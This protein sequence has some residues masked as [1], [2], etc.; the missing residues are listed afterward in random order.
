MPVS[1]VLPHDEKT[2]TALTRGGPFRLRSPLIRAALGP[3]DAIVVGGGS[4]RETDGTLVVYVAVADA[5]A[6]RIGKLAAAGRLVVLLQ[7]T[8]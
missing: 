6:E 4:H 1:A 2:A 3:W 7:G 8:R 5:D